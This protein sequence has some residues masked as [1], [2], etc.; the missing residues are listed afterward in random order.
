MPRSEESVKSRFIFSFLQEMLRRVE[1]KKLNRYLLYFTVNKTLFWTE[2]FGPLSGYMEIPTSYVANS[3]KTFY[4]KNF[5][6]YSTGR[7]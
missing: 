4:K 6:G 2:F 1:L 3:N 7:L 5:H